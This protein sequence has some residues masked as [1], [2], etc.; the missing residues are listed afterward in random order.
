MALPAF[1]ATSPVANRIDQRCRDDGATRMRLKYAPFYHAAT[2]QAGPV[3]ELDGRERI[4]LSSN[5][6]L[7]LAWDRRVQEAAQE[8]V[9]RWGTS[10]TGARLA[11]GSRR[12]HEE[13]EE[14][15]AAFLGKEACHVSSAGY[16]SCLSA[17]A[18]FTGPGDLVFADRS[19]HACM[20]DGIRLSGATVERFAHNN[21]NALREALEAAPPG[22]ARLLAIEGVYSMEGHIAPL[23]ELLPLARGHGCF[24]VLDDAHGFGVLGPQGAGTA[25]HFGRT[26]DV[27]VI[28]GSLSKS[29]A[30]TGGFVAGARHVIDYLRTH[31]RQTI[32]SAALAPA[33]AAAALAA[34]R[35][36]RSEPEHRARLQANTTRYNTLL[37]DLGL[38]TWGSQT[39]AIPIVLG[40]RERAYLFWKALLEKDVFTVISIAPGVPPGKDLV[41]TAI[42][43]AHTDAH[44]DRIGEALAH[45][46]RR[47]G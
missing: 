6:Y 33:Q 44:L 25:N 2:S 16:I 37:R 31:S 30:S 43:A 13:L 3:I 46:A 1:F 39:P 23:D 5:D 29:L 18:A 4:M 28:C 24:T 26:K 10:T 12:Y 11:N 19:L 27:D 35:I 7:G 15:L 20:W 45:A 8:A 32:F 21:A 42:S 36:L 34:L 47:C 38:D 14:E 9:R 22:A 40:T 17:I 41:R